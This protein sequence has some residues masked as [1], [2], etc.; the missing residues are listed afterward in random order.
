MTDLTTLTDDVFWAGILKMVERATLTDS[1]GDG[2]PDEIPEGTM[3]DEL[4]AELRRRLSERDALRA[5]AT[6][7]GRQ[8]DISDLTDG[9]GHKAHDLQALHE[10]RQALAARAELASLRADSGMSDNERQVSALRFV[11]A[12]CRYGAGAYRRDESFVRLLDR[13]KERC[14]DALP[15]VTV[16]ER[17]PKER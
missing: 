14:E 12:Q 7:L 13:L 17:V 8:M 10:L 1:W 15:T 4:E 6:E 3:Y 2:Y 11:I 9:L 16:D 5:A